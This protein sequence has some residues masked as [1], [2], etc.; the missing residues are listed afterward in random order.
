VTG[1]GGWQ[2]TNMMVDG[3]NTRL[4]VI[5]P[6]DSVSLAFNYLVG[7][8]CGLGKT[9][10]LQ[11]QIGTDQGKTGCVFDGTGVGGGFPISVAT[12]SQN[13]YTTSITLATAGTYQIM[14][15]PAASTTGCGTAWTNGQPDSN[16]VIAIVCVA[17]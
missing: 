15:D 3:A 1:H 7:V 17:P 16:E 13:G 2:T 14:V 11:L 12:H 10:P 6:G 9:C 5:Q 8:Q 4:A